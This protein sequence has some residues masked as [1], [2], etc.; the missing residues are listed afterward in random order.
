MTSFAKLLAPVILAG[1]AITAAPL[2]AQV[3]GAIATVD[4]ARAIISTTA[5]QTAYNQVGQTYTQQIELRR[6]KGQERQTLLQTFDTNGDKEV[7]DAELA[8]KQNSPEFAQLQ[9]LEQE[10]A[11]LSNQVDSAR[12]YA[13][14]QVLA[15][16]ATALQEVVTQRQIQLVIDPATV[17]YIAPE[18]DITAQVTTSLNAKVTAVGIVPPA[19]WQPSREGVQLFQQIQQTLITAQMIQQQQQQQQGNAQAPTGR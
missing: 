10:I 4:P 18:G 17:V 19:G 7:D 14:E 11:Q 3:T 12:V 6:T 2:A 5:L 9:A 13:I 15:Q 8:A 1:T 16:Y